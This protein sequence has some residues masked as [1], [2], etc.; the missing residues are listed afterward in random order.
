MA[1]LS[2]GLAQ[3]E[4]ATAS[5][6]VDAL[7]HHA[8]IWLPTWMEKRAKV[9]TRSHIHLPENYSGPYG[10]AESHQLWISPLIAQQYNISD[11]L[12]QFP[13]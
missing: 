11:D 8:T 3:E 6:Q 4:A 2:E 13:A 12:T 10:V 7:I 9:M 1:K 5:A